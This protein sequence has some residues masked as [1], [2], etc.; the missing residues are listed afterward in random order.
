[1]TKVRKNEAEQ[2]VTEVV[3]HAAC[4]P[5]QA[6]GKAALA[7][8]LNSTTCGCCL[9]EFK[10]SDRVTLLPCYHVFCDQCIIGRRVTGISHFSSLE[11]NFHVLES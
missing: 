6:P 11:L 10:K 9:R 8:M 3:E 4:P 5:P 1:M 2:K 7:Q